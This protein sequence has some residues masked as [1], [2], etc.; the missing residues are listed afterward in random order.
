MRTLPMIILEKGNSLEI[1]PTISKN[2][3]NVPII[4][5]D[6]L[7]GSNIRAEWTRKTGFTKFGTR[8]RLLDPSEPVLGEAVGI[9]LEKYADDLNSIFRK[10]RFEKTTA[11]FEFAG[12]NSFAGYH[13]DEPHNV[14]LFDLHVFKR[15]IIP[16]QEFV[17]L[18]GD[19]VELPH[20]VHKG[21]VNSVFIDDIHHSRVED[22]TFEGVVCKGPLDNRNRPIMFKLKSKAW[23]E[24]LKFKT[25]DD[26]ALFE[27]L[28]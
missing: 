22:V 2:T 25:G 9:F 5:F 21:K 24:K 7:D 11:Y 10:Q 15:G 26:V 3:L 8:R 14:T 19:K 17:K 18:F 12:E 16:A 6:K 23:L 27:K 20:I 1:Y 4:A 28:A 13:E